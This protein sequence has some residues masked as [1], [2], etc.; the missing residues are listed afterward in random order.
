M[1]LV[2][3]GWSR[4]PSRQSSERPRERHQ[5]GASDHFGLNFAPAERHPLSG[6]SWCLS[7]AAGA[8]ASRGGAPL[9]PAFSRLSERNDINKDKKTV[10]VVVRPLLAPS[11]AAIF[12]NQ[13]LGWPKKKEKEEKEKSKTKQSDAPS[14]FAARADWLLSALTQ[15]TCKWRL[16]CSRR[17]KPAEPSRSGRVASDRIG[18]DR[19]GPVSCIIRASVLA[20]D[21]SGAPMT[22]QRLATLCNRAALMVERPAG[23][24]AALNTRS[25]A[26]Q[27]RAR[28]GDN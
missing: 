6:A 12:V 4:K 5:N 14:Q 10:F 11:W 9:W 28:F 17:D 15:P 21:P 13:S 8:G 2:G 18:P 22:R 24:L 27:A 19:C 20:C 25:R 3:A 7:P 26:R 23:W 1:R 16:A